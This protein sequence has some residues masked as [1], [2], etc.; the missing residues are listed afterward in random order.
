MA[1]RVDG[2]GEEHGVNMT[3]VG[4][5]TG[6]GRG[7][8]EEVGTVAEGDEVFLTKFEK[9]LRPTGFCGEAVDFCG[10][11][12]DFCGEAVDFCGE[13]VDFCGEAVDL[14]GEVVGLC[15]ELAAESALTSKDF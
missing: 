11:A 3:L 9:K 2:T 1:S 5:A 13:A 12:V 10:E 7:G 15:G 4:E 8:V 6:V 14:C